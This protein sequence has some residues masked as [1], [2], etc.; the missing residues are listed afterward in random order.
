MAAASVLS[1]AGCSTGSTAFNDGGGGD[2][3]TSSC[4]APSTLCSG[5]CVDTKNDNANCGACGTACK[6]GEVCSQGACG[7]TCGGGTTL[8]G[9][10]CADTKIDPNNCGGCNT[11]C[12]SGE[13]C[14]DGK[15]ASTCASDQTFCGG[16]GGSSYCANTKTDN[17]N[18]GGCGVACGNG[19]VCDNGACTSTCGGTDGGSET[20]CTPDGGTAFCTNTSTDNANCGGCGIVCGSGQVCENSACVNGCASMDGGVETLCQ[21]DAGSPY[22]A[23]TT[24]DIENCGAC[25][26]ACTSSIDGGVPVCVSSKCETLYCPPGSQTFSYTGGTQSFTIPSCVTSITVDVRGAGG[27]EAYYTTSFGTGGLGGR[28][29]ATLAVQPSDV[30]T[31]VVGGA[32]ANGTA[33]VGGG[34]GYNGG[35]TG[36]GG[37]TIQNQAGGGGGGGSVV[38]VNSVAVAIGG[39]GGGA[40]SC[41]GVAYNGGAGGGLTGQTPPTN[42][43]NGTSPT[44]GTQSAGGTAGSYSGWCT[45]SPGTQGSGGAGCSPSGGG[46]AG[47]GLYGGGGGAWYPGAGGSG[48]ASSSATNVTLTQ[49]YQSGNGQ[50]IVSW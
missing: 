44:G 46:G 33:G 21:P 25:G 48:Y 28:T 1:A 13:V 5:T 49:A 31:I 6:T 14:A 4:G 9:S 24:S 38:D 45:A 30:V 39:G 50:V 22:C 10:S 15:C 8:C 27:G 3:T 16:D 40:A 36:G 2:G 43:G 32:G 17:A 18:C 12:S 37:T 42:C 23:N 47:G 20:L 34:G 35:A 11:K 26:V 19:Q 41:S 29:Q 7:T